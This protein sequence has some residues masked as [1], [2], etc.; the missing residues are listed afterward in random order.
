MYRALHAAGVPA[1]RAVLLAH[2]REVDAVL[3]RFDRFP[4]V[5]A[6]RDPA[7]GDVAVL[8]HDPGEV[9][10]AVAALA[11]PDRPVLL[12]EH[13]D[14]PLV[15]VDT[16][17]A[18]GRHLLAGLYDLR[19]D[20]VGG[21]PLVRD[22]V[23][24]KRPGSVHAAVA[25]H[26]ADCLDVLGVREGAAHGE[27]CV[28]P[29][30]PRLLE[31]HARVTDASQDPGLHRPALGYSHADLTAERFVDPA[32]FAL[33]FADPYR[34]DAA[35]ATVALHVPVAGVVT[36]RP[37]LAALEALPGFVRAERLPR[38]GDAVAGPPTGTGHAGTAYLRHPDETVLRR[39]LDR[40]H[41]LE[42]RGELYSLT[43]TPSRTC[44]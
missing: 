14:G 19:V 43:P 7:G 2:R 37:G 36:A 39:S 40:L 41:A 10:S 42:D 3:G 9:R 28:T 21:R 22:T 33:R 31:L 18:G 11:A 13:L 16:V 30:G 4:L 27:V 24:R 26:V 25:A 38:V 32:A 44:G 35:L 6:L 17:S 20:R 15:A 12:R 8:C 23:L 29:A 34:P 5:V 1:V